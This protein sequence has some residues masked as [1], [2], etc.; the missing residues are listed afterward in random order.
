MSH[1]IID[2]IVNF[3]LMEILEAQMI[4]VREHCVT[5]YEHLLRLGGRWS[6]RCSR[7][8]R[9]KGVLLFRIG[10]EGGRFGLEVRIKQDV[11][12]VMLF[13]ELHHQLQHVF[14]GHTLPCLGIYGINRK[15]LARS[16][17]QFY[18]S[19]IHRQLLI[20]RMLIFHIFSAVALNQF[21]MTTN[22]IQSQQQLIIY[23]KL[24]QLTPK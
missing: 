2:E 4:N 17:S 14:S 6:G 15:A 16:D 5:S 22:Q 11:S 13:D 19:Q 7:R 23:L 12:Q 20:H 24:R 3:V 18:N 10:I 1:L 8:R 9:E 21:L